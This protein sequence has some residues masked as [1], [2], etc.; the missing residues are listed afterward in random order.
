MP[1]QDAPGLLET[2]DGVRVQCCLLRRAPAALR[3]VA[4]ACAR[5]TQA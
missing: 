5:L 4:A 1:A 3:G 2:G